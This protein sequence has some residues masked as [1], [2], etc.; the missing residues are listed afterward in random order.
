VPFR[1]N[2]DF[3]GRESI[4]VQLKELLAY[5]EGY[6]PRAVLYGLGGTG[7]STI[8]IFYFQKKWLK[9]I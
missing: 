1:R 7:Y 9:G 3:I 6:Q 8:S 4:L 2:E 5:K